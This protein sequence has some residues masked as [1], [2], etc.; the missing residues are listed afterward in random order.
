MKKIFIKILISI[1]ILYI[2]LGGVMFMFQEKYIFFPEKL[3]KS[4]QFDFDQKFEEIYIKT[5]DGID[6]HGLLFSVDNS[7]GLIFYLHGNAGSLSSWGGVART[8]TDLNY[9]VFILD[10]R[11]YGKSDG[12]ISSEKQLFSDIQAAYD[13]LKK[14]YAEN[15]IIILGYS[16]GAGPAAK[17][18]STNNPKLLILQAPYYNLSDLMRKFYPLIPTFFLKYKFRTD[19]YIKECKMPVVIFHGDQDEVI[20]YGS[21]LKL[22]KLFKPGDRLISLEGQYHNGM[23][24]NEDYLNEIKKILEK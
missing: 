23:S 12:S 24:D 13:N 20:Y 4:F 2:F 7:K 6:L 15:K 14:K 11:G 1:L 3:E 16:I 8:Y 22:K 17:I 9:D 21:S 5:D 10:Y 18:A 19:K